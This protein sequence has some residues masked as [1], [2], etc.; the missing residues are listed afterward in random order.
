MSTTTLSVVSPAMFKVVK[1]EL[2]D[3][4]SPPAPVTV[5]PI[6]AEVI[7]PLLFKVTVVNVPATV[8]VSRSP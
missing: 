6:V 4:V 3:T 8:T 5:P 2:L 7:L 1:S